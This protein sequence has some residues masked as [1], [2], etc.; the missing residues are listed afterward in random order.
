MIRGTRILL[1]MAASGIAVA[2]N[3]VPAEP[4]LHCDERFVTTSSKL[5]VCTLTDPQA[6]GTEIRI[7]LL[8]I[9]SNDEKRIGITFDKTDTSS[10]LR[11]WRQALDKRSANWQP[12]GEYSETGTNDN[13]HLTV[14]AGPGVRFTI[15]SPAR[16]SKTLDLPSADFERFTA[17]LEKAAAFVAGSR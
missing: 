5:D 14:S 11:L 9:E 6:D 2:A 13:S 4:S 10:I 1:A 17:E 15:E 16:G 12:V 8:G 3:A 7:L